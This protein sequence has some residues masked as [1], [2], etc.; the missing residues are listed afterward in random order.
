MEKGRNIRMNAKQASKN[1]NKNKISVRELLPFEV[2]W[3]SYDFFS[4]PPRPH[5]V[6]E[7]R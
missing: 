3:F 2:A 4:S 1:K 6:L 7:L 5:A